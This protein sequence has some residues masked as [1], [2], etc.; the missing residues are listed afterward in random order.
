MRLT[1]WWRPEFLCIESALYLHGVQSINYQSCQ[2]YAEKDGEGRLAQACPVS[3]ILES[4]WEQ[5]FIPQFSS[6]VVPAHPDALHGTR[7]PSWA[8]SLCRCIEIL[9][10]SLNLYFVSRVPW[11]SDTGGM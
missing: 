5:F 7:L 1:Q 6:I 8:G 4:P 3:F 11:D 10:L 9:I 2:D